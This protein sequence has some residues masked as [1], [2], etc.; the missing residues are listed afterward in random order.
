MT[1]RPVTILRVADLDQA[2]RFYHHGLSFALDLHGAA[3]GVAQVSPPQGLPLLLAARS[4]VDLGRFAQ[5]NFREA[6]AGRRLYFVTETSLATYRDDL[7]TRGLTP[8]ELAYEEDG[9]TTLELT[10]PDGYIVSFWSPAQLPDAERIRRFQAAPQVLVEALA[11]LTEEQLDLVREPG[12]WSIRQTVH[13]MADSAGTSLVRLLTALAE[14]GRPFRNN[15]YSQDTWVTNL[16]HDKRP[17][18][19][20]VAL[21]TAV[22]AHVGALLAHL[23]DALDRTLEGDLAGRQTVRIMV[24]MLTS[25]VHGHTQQIVETRRVHGV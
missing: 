19:T 13:H 17:V 16:G 5:E 2:L 22:H 24:A 23:P 10:D 14:P 4:A 18:G 6:P 21:I 25:H 11:D 15:P 7:C 9:A 1:R 12:K 20:A 8:A 3:A